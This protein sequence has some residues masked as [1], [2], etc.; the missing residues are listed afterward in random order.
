MPGRVFVNTASFGAYAEFVQRP[1]YRDAKAATALA[2][3]P[4]LLTGCTGARLTAQAE[5]TRLDDPQ[6]LLVSN[7]PYANGQVLGGRPQVAARRR[8]PW[9][10]GRA[11]RRRGAGR[12]LRPARRAV[13]CRDRADAP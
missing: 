2:E 9:P 8:C 3:L 11:R 1:E 7:N 4:D 10:A 6:A 13:G 12:G 5:G